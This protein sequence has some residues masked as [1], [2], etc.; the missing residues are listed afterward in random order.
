[1]RMLSSQA[2]LVPLLIMLTGIGSCQMDGGDLN[3]YY[4]SDNYYTISLPEGWTVSGHEGNGITAQD[5]SNAARGI[6]YLSRLHEGYLMLPSGTTPESYLENYMAQDFSLRESK[7]EGLEIIGYEDSSF[8]NNQDIAALLSGFA[9][10]T[11]PSS[12][13]AIRCEFSI[14]G[15]PSQGSFVIKTRDLY[16]Y[17]TI[18]D[19]VLGI[20]APFDQFDADSPLLLQAFNSVQLNPEYRNIC[21]PPVGGCT[22]CLDNDCCDHDCDAEGRCG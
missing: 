18:V 21:I 3:N 17:G 15:I 5:A 16:G 22:K 2:I 10:S 1:L 11:T 13:K 8:Y 9:Y 19:Y 6:V 20:Y 14:N 4:S 12:A 7:I